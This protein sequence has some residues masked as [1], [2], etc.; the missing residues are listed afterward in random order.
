MNPILVMCMGLGY[1]FNMYRN[2]PLVREGGVIIMTHP[3]YRDF[4]PVHH[5]SYIDFFEQV[6]ADTTS[7]AEMSRKWE[8]QYAEDEWYK[9]LYRTGNA[10]HG[11]HPFYAWYWGAHGLQHAGKVIIVG[12]DPP[13]VSRLGFTPASTMDDAFEIA[14]DVVGRDATITHLHAPALLVADV[15]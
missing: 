15:H 6:L 5:P 4:N 1:L 11:V 8:K 12:G 7:P 9:H 3:C 10:Y 2:K 13:T 14:S